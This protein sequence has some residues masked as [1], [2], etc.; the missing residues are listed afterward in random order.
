MQD[1]TA[2]FREAFNKIDKYLHELGDYDSRKEFASVLRDLSRTNSNVRQYMSELDTMRE[3]RNL[4]VHHEGI[5]RT[6]IATP[7]PSTVDR[8]NEIY[9]ALT[10]PP[11]VASIMIKSVAKTQYQDLLKVALA[12]MGDKGYTI[13]P[14][15]EDDRVVA[16][17]SEYSVLKWCSSELQDDGA[18]LVAVAVND[19]EPF[20]D[21]PDRQDIN[22][23]YQ[24][25]PRNLPLAALRDIF[26]DSFEQEMRL[27]AVFVTQTGKNS[28]K[29]LGIVTSWDLA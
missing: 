26:R 6:P 22:A 14:V 20:L 18:A 7:H 13:L 29:L 24:F 11:T 21:S 27:N 3:L 23:A 2:K 17:L 19:I 28:E 1:N 15:V 8:L 12:T 5:W 4:L 16:V 10:N 25:V 9:E